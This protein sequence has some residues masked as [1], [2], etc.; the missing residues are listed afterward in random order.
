MSKVGFELSRAK[1]EKVNVWLV[2]DNDYFRRTMEKLINATVEMKCVEAFSSCEEA[3]EAFRAEPPPEVILLDI[4]LPG[5]SGLQGIAKFKA[6]SASTHI[7]ILTVHDD[8]AD[9]FDAICAGASGYL[10]KDSPPEKAIAAVK[11]VLSGGAPMNPRIARRVLEM[12][13]RQ[14]TPKG[15]YGLSE[16]EKEILTLLVDGFTQKKIANDLF[17]SFHTV[18]THLKNIYIKLQ[19]HSRTGALS[20]VFKEKLL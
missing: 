3:I 1:H 13:A 15:E 9:V 19:V 16:R 2:E 5:M 4:G 12:F 17:L 6:L 14:G 8:D 10:L 11:E 18:N 20:K 7:V